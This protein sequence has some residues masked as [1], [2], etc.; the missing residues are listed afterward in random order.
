MLKDYN[1]I[2]SVLFRILS[3]V[4]LFSL[5]HLLTGEYS[6]QNR[7]SGMFNRHDIL[8]LRCKIKI[9]I[10]LPKPIGEHLSVEYKINY[11]SNQSNT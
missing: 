6:R 4:I 10:F 9:N 2:T 7:G 1:I 11:K 3:K 8:E 5:D